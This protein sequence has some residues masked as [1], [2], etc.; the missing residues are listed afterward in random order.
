M[1]TPVDTIEYR[2]H[3]IEIHSEEYPS[4]PRTEWDNLGT[5]VA[6]WNRC[7]LGD[8]KTDPT[9]EYTMSRE[10]AEEFSCRKDIISLPLYVYEHSG[11]TMSTGS[12]YPYNDRWDAGCA[13]FIY[14]TK[15]K[16]PNTKKIRAE[17]NS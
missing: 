11:I 6:F 3:T 17:S 14:I 10:E 16:V 12:G 1:S 13:G 7:D 9:G 5:M 2:N 8:N 4:N 15:E